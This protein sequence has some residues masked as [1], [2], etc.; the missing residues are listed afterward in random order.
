MEG[1]FTTYFALMLEEALAERERRI[2]GLRYGLVDGTPWTLQAIAEDL[3]ISRERVR[4][5]VTR[6]MRKLKYKQYTRKPESAGAQFR[7]YLHD[8]VRFGEPGDLDRLP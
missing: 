1:E 8:L 6:I 5:L 3:G 7:Q 2:I 4:Q